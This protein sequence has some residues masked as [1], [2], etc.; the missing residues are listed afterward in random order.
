MSDARAAMSAQPRNGPCPCG[1]GRR[2]KEC[3]GALG[4]PST[5][6]D[7]EIDR[8]IATLAAA[9]AAQKAGDLATAAAGYRAVLADVPDHFDALH[10]LGVVLLQDNRL[11]EAAALIARAVSLRPEV[12]AARQNLALVRQAG[13]IAAEEVA[14]CR[15]VLPR[16]A[17][18]CVDPAPPFLDGV[19]HGDGVL[20]VFAGAAD[21]IALA[22]RIADAAVARGAAL[23]VGTAASKGP[24]GWP[25]VDDPQFAA[26]AG[27]TVIVVG[28]DAAIGDWTLDAEP[29]SVMLVAT[30]DAPC[31]LFDRL[32]EAS[33]QGRW[34]V[35]LA[36]PDAAV[37]AATKLPMRVLP[38]FDHA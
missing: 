29:R 4:A 17:R 30:R 8:R 31:L 12:E 11:D 33:G 7:A 19:G 18:L 1:S 36:T 28:L 15:A 6:A 37:A 14:I 3:H 23:S 32:R 24:R 26:T 38:T 21:D 13:V 22:R 5:V 10:M 16:L 27:A 35:V 9:L 25:S 34:R 2:Y 20:A